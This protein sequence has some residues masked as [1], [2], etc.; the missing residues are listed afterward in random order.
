MKKLL[1]TITALS[2]LTIGAHAQILIWDVSGDSSPATLL[3]DVINVNLQTSSSLN[4]LTRVG[5]GNPG[6]ANAYNSNGWNLTNTFNE[7]DDYIT[8]TLQA[9]SGYEAT[10]TSLQYAMNGSGTGPGTGRWG[11]R[12]GSGSFTLQTTFAIP[13]ALPSSLQIWDFTDFTTDQAVEFRFWA[14]G[15]TAIGGGTSTAAGT[16]RVGNIAGNDL[17]LNGSVALIPEPSTISLVAGLGLLALV[18]RRRMTK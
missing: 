4:T 1:L 16:V 6:A 8:F 17:V 15:T 11:Y 10:F 18:L 5:L 12:I 3:A 7:S 13:S 2:A 9:T 14:F